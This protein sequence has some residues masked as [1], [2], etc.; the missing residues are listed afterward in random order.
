MKSR[1]RISAILPDM[2]RVFL[3]V[4]AASMVPLAVGAYYGEWSVLPSMAAAPVTFFILSSLLSTVKGIHSGA[5]HAVA[6][7]SVAAT[8]FVCAMIS[9]IP[10]MLGL[11]IS[12]TDSVFEAMSG[13]TDTGLTML[14]D[15]DAV[16]KTL[17]FWRSFMQWLGGL[18][19]VAF[20]IALSR[21]PGTLQRGLYRSEGRTESFMPSV[22]ATAVSMWRI[23]IIVTLL[24]IGLILLS[25]VSLWDATNIALAAIA[26]GGFSVHTEG[27]LYYQNHTLEYLLI[28]VMLAGAMPFK[29]YYMMYAR[30]K[31]S[32]FGDHQARLLL[33]L[34]AAG[35]AVTAFD[36]VTGN[37]VDLPTAM[38]ESIFMV[39]S[40][41]TCTGF[42]N[43]NPFEWTGATVLFISL[44]MIIG[45][46]SGSTSG[47][48]KLSRIITGFEGLVWWFR[49]VFVSGRTIVPFRHEGKLIPKDIAES[50]V[51]RAMF[52]IFLFILTALITSLLFLHL[53]ASG[54]FEVSDVIFEV[55]S[56]MCNVGL[57]TGF[58]NPDI[59]IASKWLFIFV[60]WFGRLEM[61]AVIVLILGLA[62][63]FD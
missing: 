16:P 29:I 20:T 49:R 33:I 42:Q 31:I 5:N 61:V 12:Y 6:I 21:R 38:R 34:A 51:S 59:S 52:V 7:A 54:P 32:F 60:M 44:L 30:R 18:G 19:I 63:G 37:L 23:Y 8:W 62:R 39:T 36:L 9:A 25:G 17:L 27:I 2:G 45:G 22:V 41:I 26:T 58:A 4:G 15:V 11:H 46:S 40:A 55:V 53:E 28:P 50:E 47:G 3:L 10:F 35:T 24:S 43:A 13:W 14:P 48:M 1:D 56:A 57:S